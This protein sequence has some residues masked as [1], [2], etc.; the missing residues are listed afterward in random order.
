MTTPASESHQIPLL[1]GIARRVRMAVEA[2]ADGLGTLIRSMVGRGDPF[3]KPN[4]DGTWPTQTRS[5]TNPGTLM[6]LRHLNDTDLAPMP[7]EDDGFIGG[8]RGDLVF[9]L[10][11]DTP[12]PSTMLLSDSFEVATNVDF[13]TRTG[14]AYAG[15]TAPTWVADKSQAGTDARCRVLVGA[16]VNIYNNVWLRASAPTLPT[17]GT[18]RAA[19]TLTE[20]DPN[21][22]HHIPLRGATYND[23]T[24]RTR[25]KFANSGG[26]LVATLDDTT[27]GSVTLGQAPLTLGSTRVVVEFDGAQVRVTIGG[28]A[29]SPGTVPTRLPRLPEFVLRA[30][31]WHFVSLRELTVET[32]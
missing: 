10:P 23:D 3:V 25:L 28:V 8:V 4:A 20:M 31:S 24:N 17:T 11:E 16:G 6:W 7:T 18:W 9:P 12:A 29:L 22:T 19:W 26:L 21:H 1:A 5:T 14:D 32:L 27:D 13:S 2:D 30:P 15:G